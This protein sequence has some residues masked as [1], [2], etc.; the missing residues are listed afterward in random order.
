V[1]LVLFSPLG[2]EVQVDTTAER[3]LEDLRIWGQQGF[4]PKEIPLGGFVLPLACHACFD[5]AYL[6]ATQEGEYVQAFGYR[7]KRRH[8]QGRQGLPEV[9]K[10]SRGAWQYE[11]EGVEGKRQGYVTLI[12]FEGEGRCNRWCR[13]AGG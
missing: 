2:H 9:I 5:W 11:E 8:L 13:R 1:R 3:W 6:G 4:R 7:W 12:R 10:Y